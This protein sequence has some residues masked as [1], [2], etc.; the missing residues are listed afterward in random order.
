MTTLSPA[1]AEKLHDFARRRRTLIATRGLCVG[2]VTLLAVMSAIVLIDWL[3]VIK[4][5]WVRWAMSLS[6]YAIVAAVVWWTCVRLLVKIPGPH[7]L[8]RLMEQADPTLRED[9]LSA[10]ELGIS[11]TDARFDSPVFRSL[12]QASVSQRVE[13]VRT[14]SLLPPRLIRRWVLIASLVLLICCGLMLVPE[15]RFINRLTRAMM[16]AAPVD[17]VASVRVRIIAPNPTEPSVPH[18][19]AV[20]VIVELSGAD[21]EQV[22][23]ETRRSG[24]DGAI[25]EIP[26][27]PVGASRQYSAAI[28]I[29]R[30]PVTYRVLAGDAVTRLYTIATGPRPHVTQ[31]A[32]TYRYP[33]YANLKSKTIEEKTG[34]IE[35]LE[36]ST[37]ELSMISDQ[38]LRAAE[39]R[40]EYADKTTQTLPLELD[41]PRDLRGKLPIKQG[42]TYRVHLTAAATGFD[43]QFDPPYVINITPDALPVIELEQPTQDVQLPADS[44]LPLKVTASD[45]LGLEGVVQ[46]ITINGGKAIEH[47]LAKK[48]GNEWQSTQPLD[49]YSLSLSPGDQV[50]L[51]FAA[52]DLAGHRTETPV[53]KITILSSGFDPAR[54]AGL[55]AKRNLAEALTAL[56]SSASDYRSALS[57]PLRAFAQAAPLRRQQTAAEVNDAGDRLTLRANEAFTLT[58]AAIAANPVGSDAEDLAIVGRALSSQRVSSLPALSMKDESFDAAKAAQA[59]ELI[60]ASSANVSK[61]YGR[62]L[63]ADESD[64]LLR[65][66][67]TLIADHRESTAA[68]FPDEPAAWQRLARRSLLLTTQIARVEAHAKE[69][70]QRDRVVAATIEQIITQKLTPAKEALAA[71]ASA[72]SPDRTIANA[73]ASIGDALTQT[74][75]QVAT[76]ASALHRQADKGREQLAIE[77]GSVHAAIAIATL[78]A[79][80]DHFKAGSAL[81]DKRRDGDTAWASD[82]SLGRRAVQAIQVRARAEEKPIDQE[83]I[84][85]VHDAVRVLETGHAVAAM[86]RLTGDLASREKWQRSEGD[87]ITRYLRDGSWF[88]AQVTPVADA[89]RDSGMIAA[90]GDQLRALSSTNAFKQ[91]TGEQV[92]RRTL[93][94]VTSIHTQLETIARDLA[95][96]R[97]LIAPDMARARAVLAAEAPTLPQTMKALA[98]ESREL[99]EHAEKTAD[100]LPAK[101]AAE[102]AKE[103]AQL[104]EKQDALDEKVGELTDALRREANAQDL[105]TDAGRQHARDADDATAMIQKPA[106][107]A[108]QELAAAAQAPQ[109]AQKAA[110]IEQAGAKDEKLA[111]ALDAAAKH[112]ENLAAGKEEETRA[113]LRE[114]EKELDIKRELDAQ[115][116]RMEKLADL[117]AKSPQEQMKALEQELAQ[118][119][120]M[121]QELGAI[122]KDAV[123]DAKTS[124]DEA[125]QKQGELAKDLAQAAKEAQRPRDHLDPQM[126]QLSDKA[127]Q[128]AQKA[129]GIE[130]STKSSSQEASQSAGEAKQALQKAAEAGR[131]AAATP[132]DQAASKAA[133]AKQMAQAMAKGADELKDAHE[134]AKGAGEAIREAER[135]ATALLA[136][137]DPSPEQRLKASELLLNSQRY[138][139]EAKAAAREAGLAAD[140]AK[141]MAD[142][143]KQIADDLAKASTEGSEAMKQAGAQ[144]AP[145]AEQAQAAAE[146]VGR[147]GRHEARMDNQ[148]AAGELG[149]SQRAIDKASQDQI[150]P[151]GDQLAQAMKP[152]EA[153]EAVGKAEAAL[154]QQAAK[155]D[156]MMQPARGGESGE[157][158]GGGDNNGDSPAPGQAGQPGGAKESAPKLSAAQGAPAGAKGSPAEQQAA[159]WMAR[160]LDE[161]DRSMNGQSTRD[162]ASFSLTNAK[163][164]PGQ[165]GE[166]PNGQAQP[167]QHGSGEQAAEAMRQAA[168]AQAQAMAEARRPGEDSPQSPGQGALPGD[169]M[170]QAG[171]P[172]QGQG[173]GQGQ[174]ERGQG[175]S[176]QANGSPPQGGQPGQGGSQPGQGGN[177]QQ[178]GALGD[179]NNLKNGEWGKL[180]SRLTRELL[181]GQR[182]EVSGEYRGA[183]EAYFRAIAKQAREKGGS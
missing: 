15:L 153:S 145:I 27:K 137:G 66:L 182:D 17:R 132:K 151:L 133:Q 168:S 54:L 60:T 183:V 26:M 115:Y 14:A 2:I 172:S 78:D 49:L 99:K 163:P 136:V 164:K 10:V 112:W 126:K 32:K 96:V 95:Q 39:L 148:P 63:I 20:S 16:P 135:K 154:A 121:K 138:Q 108:K 171:Q 21:A 162:E 158:P 45:D 40:I 149:K 19:D 125:A 11:Q 175:N 5:Q 75:K 94:H 143:A 57:E 155:L 102:A 176:Q 18:N 53:R 71:A 173:Q 101:D 106:A 152:G 38:P 123:R 89:L 41:S 161:L 118:N 42:G 34:D 73:V 128:L 166:S 46:S 59:I 28:Q 50:A 181:E 103:V 147:A 177:G 76:V 97:Q 105:F 150:K 61:A 7:A 80:A 58:L 122:S 120:A 13:R 139:N 25:E 111:D 104:R 140:E 1:I 81:N 178:G 109:A 116:G 4:A 129:A 100:G 130:A 52:I 8:A 119:P 85:R 3:V 70:A 43:N 159:Q 35:T 62:T 98:A 88:I 47:I 174:S 114:A 64:S 44:A 169:A 146:D 9:L 170:A 90:A 37:V 72:A 56:A 124:L 31:F 24:D 77:A 110:H 82:L 51:R 93:L 67:T 86:H 36:G 68:P 180:P 83:R 156:S 165:N 69:L 22:V 131:E 92:T 84:A 48:P 6:G 33:A 12:L 107:E 127:A 29:G 134:Q 87:A 113:A 144:Q 30:D 141:R 179:A 23:L 160:A 79:A 55:Q 167:G 142:A 74:R 91:T 157:K 117:A 65:D